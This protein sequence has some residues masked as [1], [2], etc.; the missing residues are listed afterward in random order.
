MRLASGAAVLL[1]LAAS[2]ACRTA[3]PP[4]GVATT[5]KPAA[6]DPGP[7][8]FTRPLSV[9]APEFRSASIDIS[10][11]S[12][13]MEEHGQS[14]TKPAIHVE[15]SDVNGCNVKIVRAELVEGGGQVR[16]WPISGVNVNQLLWSGVAC[17]KE[18]VLLGPTIRPPAKKLRVHLRHSSRGETPI[19]IALAFG[20]ASPVEATAPPS[21][22]LAPDCTALQRCCQAWRAKSEKDAAACDDIIQ[23][24]TQLDNPEL[25]R[26]ALP[27]YAKIG[28]CGQ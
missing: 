24:A 10:V 22:P 28:G 4:A 9:A 21:P 27:S 26:G 19:D 2:T 17:V 5:T 12:A 7:E 14:L 25:C 15:G 3:P 20:K 13:Q 23:A 16:E 6:P 18:V 1:A 8:K 11:G